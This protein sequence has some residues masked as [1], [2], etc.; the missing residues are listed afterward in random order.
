V[1]R[2]SEST[3]STTDKDEISWEIERFQRDGYS[4][5]VI[6]FHNAVGELRVITRLDDADDLVALLKDLI[7]RLDQ[8]DEVE[9]E[10]TH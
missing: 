1:S 3:T 7:A 10:P 9:M 5:C 2:A 4:P 8:H 6:I